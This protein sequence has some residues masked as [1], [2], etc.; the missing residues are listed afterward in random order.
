MCQTVHWTKSTDG[1]DIVPIVQTIDN[2]ERNHRLG[3]IYEIRLND[4][5]VPLIICTSPLPLLAAEGHAEAACLLSSLCRYAGTW[6]ETVSH[7]L[8]SMSEDAFR[9]LFS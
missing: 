8:Y 7:T 1:T 4:A 9:K 5:D 2:F 3:M 6:K